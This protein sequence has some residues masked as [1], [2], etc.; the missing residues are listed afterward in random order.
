MD[1]GELSGLRVGDPAPPPL[2]RR[3]ESEVVANWKGGEPLVSILCPT[4]QHVDFIEDALRGFLGQDTD[5]AFE[6]L[7]RDDASTDGTAR[8]VAEFAEEYPKIIRPIFEKVNR[9]PQTSALATLVSEARGS[10]VA[11]CEGDDYWTDPTKLAR[12]SALLLADESA[13][14]SHHDA[15]VVA[16]GSVIRVNELSDRRQRELSPLDLRQSG[17]LPLRTLMVRQNA[18][19]FLVEAHR[20]GWRVNNE[21]QLLTAH[22]GTL[23]GSRYVP[24]AAMAVYRK[25]DGGLESGNDKSVRKGRSGMSS[26]WIAFRLREQGFVSDSEEHLVRA[27]TK[28]ASAPVFGLENPELWL[29]WRLLRRG[30]AVRIRQVFGR[31]RRR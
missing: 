31:L 9:W 28:F 2:E 27:V 17:Y 7:V 23:G 25:H 22:L 15:V 20:R 19:D 10:L 21:D 6:I 13:I 12:Q 11:I 4:Y 14:A 26:F 18:L 3:P 29:G 24:G 1:E 5:F 30:L 16:Q 8:I